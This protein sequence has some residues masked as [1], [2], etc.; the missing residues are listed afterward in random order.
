LPERCVDHR[1]RAAHRHDAP[2]LEC[3]RGRVDW[4]PWRIVRVTSP[5]AEVRRR[6]PEPSDHRTVEFTERVML[7][8]LH[9]RALRRTFRQRHWNDQQP[10]RFRRNGVFS[11]V[12]AR[13]WCRMRPDVEKARSSYFQRTEL[14]SINR[15]RRQN[16]GSRRA[17]GQQ[18]SPRGTVNWSRMTYRCGRSRR[19]SSAIVL[20]V[21]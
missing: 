14:F 6:R 17:A 2:A 19:T 16:L 10:V 8:A 9:E 21:A 12:T 15:L 13:P 3:S 5:L 11:R 20:G 18:S 7:R 1:Q 4:S